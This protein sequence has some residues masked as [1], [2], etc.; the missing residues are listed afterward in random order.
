MQ[1]KKIIKIIIHLF[2]SPANINHM[3]IVMVLRKDNA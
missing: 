1:F 2:N 3:I